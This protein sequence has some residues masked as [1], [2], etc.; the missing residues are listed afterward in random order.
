MITLD[1]SNEIFNRV[2]FLRLEGLYD[3]ANL[4][5]PLPNIPRSTR[6]QVPNSIERYNHYRYMA[7]YKK[8]K[9][10]IEEIIGRKLYPTYFFDRFYFTGQELKYQMKIKKLAP[11]Q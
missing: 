1:T 7:D 9:L 3:P 11:Y 2:G 10:A 8:I 6:E 4:A 5:E